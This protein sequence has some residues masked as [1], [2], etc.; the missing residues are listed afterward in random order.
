[1][2]FQLEWNIEGEQQ[3]SRVLNGVNVGMRNLRKPFQ[4]AGDNL[5]RTFETEVFQ[6]RGRVIDAEPWAPLSPVTIARKARSGYP[7]TPLI[8]T[9]RMQKSFRSVATSDQAVVYN[10]AEYFKYHQS[11]APRKKLPRRVMMKLGIRQ[12]EEVVKIFH[13]YLYK[14]VNQA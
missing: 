10:T 12:R 11:N 1:M 9:G 13:T 7:L 8:A 6:T 2:P 14:V 3:L 4:E 5:R